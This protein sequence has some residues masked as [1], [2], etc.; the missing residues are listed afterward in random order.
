MHKPSAAQRKCSTLGR[1]L[2]FHFHVA[3]RAGAS[4]SFANLPLLV[5]AHDSSFLLQ[6]ALD[7]K[8]IF[9]GGDKH[10]SFTLARTGA[11]NRFYLGP[12]WT[13]EVFFTSREWPQLFTC[14]CTRPPF[15]PWPTLDPEGTPLFMLSNRS[16]SR[17]ARASHQPRLA[18]T[19]LFPPTLG[20][21]NITFSPYK[22]H[23]TVTRRGRL[24][25]F[26]LARGGRERFF[27]N[28]FH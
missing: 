10:K 5:S 13:R 22:G 9:T 24:K 2:A 7:P 21:R 23:E 15:V 1:V 27:F 20:L 18:Q 25:S 14:A 11:R 28:H 8:A 12:R 17:I 6:P 16:R 3:L 4:L 26:F 19:V